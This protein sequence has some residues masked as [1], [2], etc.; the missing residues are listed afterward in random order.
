MEKDDGV[1]AIYHNFYGSDSLSKEDI[2]REF[3]DNSRHIPKRKNGNYLYHEIMS[4]ETKHELSKD[5]I[6]EILIDVGEIYLSER[7]PK[8]IAF[9]NIHLDTNHIHMHFCISAN[10]VG[11]SRRVRLDKSKF[12]NIQKNLETYIIEKY[13]ELKQ[14]KVYNKSLEQE[15]VKTTNNE[16]A[17]KDRTGK[18]SKKEEIKTKF[19]GIFEQAQSIDDLKK[20]LSNNSFEIYERGNTPGILDLQTGQKYR[21]KTLGLVPHYEALKMR[22]TSKEEPKK[23]PDKVEELRSIFSNK[24]DKSKEKWEKKQ[25]LMNVKEAK[26]LNLVDV[27]ASFW[28]IPARIRGDDVWYKSPFR[29]EKTPS[30]KISISRNVWYDFGIGEGG[31][32]IDL[33]MKL[34]NEQSVSH[35][36]RMIWDRQSFWFPTQ[37]YSLPITPRQ[38]TDE[39]VIQSVREIT[40]P[41]LIYYIE[42]K[43]GLDINLIRAYASEIHYSRGWSSFVAIWHANEIWGFEIRD[44]RFKG[45]INKKDITH[46]QGE[47]QNWKIAVFEGLFDFLALL[48]LEKRG[49]PKDDALV[50]NSVSLVDRAE[51]FIK[52]REWKRVWGARLIPR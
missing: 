48:S 39:T 33:F 46:F 26:A 11:D 16:Q 40:N 8:Q 43:R 31:T 28:F 4:F 27:L 2:I 42:K 19:H 35:V 47:Q 13:P 22:L 14:S 30:F 21:L 34:H 51:R 24:K 12:A 29:D 23:E 37:S 25:K 18:L 10:E 41:G 6:N 52:E 50:M 49:L 15:K 5:R 20:L 36:L 17:F 9:S 3:I 45:T 1:R 32:I 7:A 44:S 38:R